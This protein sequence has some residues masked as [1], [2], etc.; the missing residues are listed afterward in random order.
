MQPDWREE[1]FS[2]ERELYTDKKFI[3][4]MDR[5]VDKIIIIEHI[6]GYV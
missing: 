3:D 2:T 6:G 5:R 4:I 1:P